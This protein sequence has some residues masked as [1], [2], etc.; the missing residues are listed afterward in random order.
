VNQTTEVVIIGGG[1]AGCAVA[2]YLAQ[3]G[4]KVTVIESQGIGMQASGYS[5]GGLNPL[6]GA[7][8]PGPLGPL[9]IESFRLHRGLWDRLREDTGIDCQG[10]IISLVK[11]A[12]DESELPELQETVDL[13]AAARQDGFSARWL[14]S[15][16]VRE[17]EPRLAQGVLR[18]VCAQGNAAL[19]SYLLTLALA[20][21]AERLG[22]NFRTGQARGLRPSV[23]GLRHGSGR[24]T[25]VVLADGEVACGQV[26]LAMGPWSREAE[27]WLGVSIPVEPLKG[28]ILRLRLSLE[29]PALAH[30]FSGGGGSLHPKPDG[31]VWCGTTEERRGF[32]KQ[33]SASAKETIWRA[34]SRL[35]PSAAQG[36]LVNH[37]ACLRPVTPDWLP[38]LG[39]APGWDNVYLCTGAGKK[40]VLLAPGMG[41]AVADLVTQGRTGITIGPCAPQRF[42]VVARG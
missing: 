6:Q 37:T 1:V 25:A 9:A 12:L 23:E 24:A 22:A 29:G 14:D 2:Y 19:D 13:F 34:A 10:R 16:E 5:A 27:A 3:A 35:M 18:G 39:Q 30:D 42:G 32:D 21:S 28:E 40:G 11:V 31:L 15:K 33:P 8:I 36:R 17:L 41:Q 38:I 20:R 7:Q 4:V 26:V